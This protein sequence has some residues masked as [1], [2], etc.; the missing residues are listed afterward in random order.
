MEMSLLKARRNYG[1]RPKALAQMNG[2]LALA[3]TKLAELALD[4]LKH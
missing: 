3:Q 2:T 1:T 4:Q